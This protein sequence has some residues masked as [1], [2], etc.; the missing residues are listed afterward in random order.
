MNKN[1]WIV[2]A[3]YGI[4]EALSKKFYREGYNLILSARDMKKLE[5]IR[6][7]LLQEKLS[8]KN[9]Q[10]VIL[11]Q[12]DVCD[13]NSLKNS[14][15]KIVEEFDR[16]DLVIFCP[17][18]YHPMS[19]I[20]F[21]L[22]MSKKIIDVNLVGFLNLLHLIVPQMVKQNS[23]QIAVI[24]SVAGYCGLPKSFVYGASKAALINLCEGIYHE[25]KQKNIDLSVVNPGFVR[26]RLTDKNKF[27]MPFIISPQE[28]TEEI[29]EGLMKQKF[30][31][32]FPRK[33]T[34]LLKF[35]RLLPYK[36]FFFLTK[37]IS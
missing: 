4:G 23:G 7:E 10:K 2:G 3:S 13:L 12:L 35:L 31:I 34:F 15:T 19:V 28:A 25:L 24:A 30:E 37:R 14:L 11:S 29:Y 26:T 36:I 32:H 5:S 1:C 21:D 17:A 20:D 16:I 22:E 9:H 33:F 6:D 27:S 8:E 18:L